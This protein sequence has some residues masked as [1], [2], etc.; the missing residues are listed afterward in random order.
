VLWQA[1]LSFQEILVL[2]A[3]RFDVPVQMDARGTMLAQLQ[4]RFRDEGQQGRSVALFIDEAQDLPVE[5]R[6]EVPL[7][8]PLTASQEPL[9]PMV[10]VGRPAL[11]QHLR[12]RRLRRVARRR[13]LHATLRPLTQ[14]ESL[15][16]I[17]Q[18]VARVALPGGPIFT[19]EALQVIGR[20]A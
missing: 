10:L 17:R 8:V 15:A 16:Y 14:A 3:R 6:K 19:Q 1:R 4:Q 18:R 20:S 7:L 11:L 2:L 5:T 12:R 9:L 13:V